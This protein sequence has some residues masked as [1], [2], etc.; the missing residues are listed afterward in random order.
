MKKT[1]RAV[2]GLRHRVD[3][4]EKKVHELIIEGKESRLVGDKSQKPFT[5]PFPPEV[6]PIAP[7]SPMVVM[8]GV[9]PVDN[10]FD[11]DYTVDTTTWI[12]IGDDS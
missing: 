8:Y 5:Y 1:L 6:K 9:T 12:N 10:T 3:A 7:E 2:R 4:L 11:K